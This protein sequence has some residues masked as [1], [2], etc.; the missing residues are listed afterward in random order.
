MRNVSILSLATVACI[1]GCNGEIAVLGGSETSGLPVVTQPPASPQIITPSGQ[2]TQ[3][4]KVDLLLMIDNSASMGDKQELLKKSLPDLVSRLVTPNCVDPQGAMLARSVAGT[5]MNGSLEFAPVQDLHVGVLTSSLGARGSDA[6]EPGPGTFD[7]ENDRAHF[8]TRTADGSP[9]ADAAATG[10]I[11][12]GPGGISDIETL[13]RDIAAL[14]GGVGANG[15]GL[16]AQLEAWYRFLVQPDPYT[17]IIV[18]PADRR[19]RYDGIDATIL[20]QR[21]DFLRPDSVLSLV[22]LTDEDESTVDPLALDGQGWAFAATTFPGSDVQRSGFMGTTAPRATLACAA[23]PFSSECTSRGYG[24]GF[25]SASNGQ[26]VPSPT[27]FGR[28]A[29][30]GTSTYYSP[31]EDP[32]NVRFHH[33]KQRFGVDPQFPLYRYVHGLLSARVPS[34]DSEHDSSGGYSG[35]ATCTNPLYAAILPSS[36]SDELCALPEGPRSQKLVVLSVIA[37]ASP[38]LLHPNM[39]TTDWTAA[40]GSD[41]VAYDFTGIDAHMIQSTAPRPGLAA[42]NAASDADPVHGRER[43]TGNADL[44]FACTFALETPR[45]CAVDD[46]SCDCAGDVVT[47]VGTICDPLHPRTQLRAKAYPGIRPLQL[48]RLLGDNAT[49]SSICPTPEVSETMVPTFDYEPAMV[50]L[51]NRMARALPSAGR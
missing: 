48:A 26:F 32:M 17:S 11:S 35:A 34:R 25:P 16:E 39:T 50:D 21:H 36:A 10:F 43:V 1:V 13:Q 42:P 29:T 45:D 33:M 37:G 14:V 22:I 30:G 4:S 49:S 51:G 24:A 47:D 28:D 7:P 12:F 18:N 19:A 8:V 41:P 46:A 38:A 6:T 3:S 2:L 31:E 5:C 27:V 44:Q 40:L 15:H 20:K 9:L 23:T